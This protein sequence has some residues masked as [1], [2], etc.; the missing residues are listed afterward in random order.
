MLDYHKCTD[1]DYDAFYPVVKQS[2]TQLNA[3]RSDPERGMLCID[4]DDEDEPIEIMG[5]EAED[6]Y[7]RFDAVLTPCNYVHRD[8]GYD[9]DSI[10]PECVPGKKE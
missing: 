2:A 6:N 4:W 8:L 7:I 9:Q 3:I 5:D 1:E 10:H